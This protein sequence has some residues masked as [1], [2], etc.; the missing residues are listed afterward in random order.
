MK[1]RDLRS[2]H[3]AIF[4]GSRML[5]EPS[6]EPTVLATSDP[7]RDQRFLASAARRLGVRSLVCRTVPE[8]VAAVTGSSSVVSDRYHPAICAAVLGKPARVLPNREPHKMHGLQHL[9]QDRTIG[10][11][12]DLARAGLKVVQAALRNTR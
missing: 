3:G 10:E 12:Q 4:S 11:L 8:L 5:V 9:L 7:R 6:R 2:E 1:V